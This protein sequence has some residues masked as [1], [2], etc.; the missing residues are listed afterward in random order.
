VDLV[1]DA[2]HVPHKVNPRIGWERGTGD[3]GRLPT[4][5]VVPYVPL[6]RTVEVAFRS[7]DPSF[8]AICLIYIELKSLGC[9]GIV[10]IKIKI[11][12][13]M[14]DVISASDRI[15]IEH[16]GIRS[17][18]AHRELGGVPVIAGVV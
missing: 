11:V 2:L 8:S 15:E 12:V 5:D 18:A 7:P 10:D 3:D 9:C 13:K 14:A 16:V 4:V 1:S 6:T 17:R